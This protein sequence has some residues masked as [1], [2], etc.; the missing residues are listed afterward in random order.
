M[1]AHLRRQS[2]WVTRREF[3]TACSAATGWAT[4]A[5]HTSAV[6]AEPGQSTPPIAALRT[7]TGVDWDKVRRCFPLCAGL[8]Y[9][10]SG[11]LGP[12]P[13]HVIEAAFQAW[14]R[15]EENPAD[16]AYGP[17]LAEAEQVRTR[18]AAFL[19]CAPDELAITQNTTEGLNA[20]AQGLDLRAGQRVLTTDQEHPGGLVG[21][22]YLA[23]KRGVVLDTVTLPQL[24]ADPAEIVRAIECQLTRD[25]RVLS[26][27]HVTFST[28]LQLPI[29]AL[30]T[31]ARANGTLLVVDG[32]QAPGQLAVDVKALGCDVYATSAHKWLLAPKGTGLLFIRREAR[33][34]IDP[35]PLAGGPGVYTAQTGTRNLPA[36]IGL[37]AAIEFHETLGTNEVAAR[38]QHL[39]QRLVEAVGGLPRLKL[40]SPPAGPLASGLVSVA[41]PEGIRGDAL[42]ETL[43]RKHH[44]TVRVV[45]AGLRFSTHVCIS[46][47]DIEKLTRALRA[48]LG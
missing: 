11:S 12:S 47:P 32:A 36:I 27:S 35:L 41:L 25:T 19:G 8:V 17:L 39:R 2:A 14:R 21:W 4:L 40:I 43:R 3:L 7:A 18:A 15:L 31:L 26:V 46:E 23:R 10:N 29:P 22:Q 38:V 16:E 37:G 9:L 5:N 48:E 28:G 42:A 13:T 1:T 24:S 45:S 44:I 34:L 20:V 33:E 6:A 30:A